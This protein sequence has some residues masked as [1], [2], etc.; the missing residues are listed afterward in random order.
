ME[1]MRKVLSGVM[2]AALLVL[3]LAAC[4]NSTVEIIE[5]SKNAGTVDQLKAAIG[6]PDQIKKVGPVA[7]W[8]YKASDGTVIFLIAGTKVTTSIASTDE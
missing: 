5:K 3:M 4:D 8:I 1:I 7:Q 6:D 2:V